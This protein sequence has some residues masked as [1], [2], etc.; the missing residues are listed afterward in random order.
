MFKKQID[1]MFQSKA[2]CR[3]A[4]TCIAFTLDCPAVDE[5][6][7]TTGIVCVKDEYAVWYVSKDG[8]DFGCYFHSA[9]APLAPAFYAKVPRFAKELSLSY[10]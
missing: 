4:L 2:Q 6:S 7:Y 3:K 10:W 1:Q 9:L 5:T 8:S